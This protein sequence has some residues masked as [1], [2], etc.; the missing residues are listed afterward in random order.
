[1]YVLSSE[2]DTLTSYGS[3]NDDVEI[4]GNVESADYSAEMTANEV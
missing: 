4:D 2:L 3:D 1:M